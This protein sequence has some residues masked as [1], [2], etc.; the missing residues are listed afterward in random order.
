MTNVAAAAFF[1]HF[2]MLEIIIIMRPSWMNIIGSLS[3][4]RHRGVV[5]IGGEPRMRNVLL[6]LSE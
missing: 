3:E 4:Y 1:Y 2:K 6:V 5:L